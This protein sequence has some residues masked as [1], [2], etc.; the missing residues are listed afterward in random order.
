[1]SVP[2]IHSSKRSKPASLA[3]EGQQLVVAAVAA[4]QAQE[5]VRQDAALKKRIELVLDE[6]RQAGAGGLLGLG[7]ETLSVLLHRNTRLSVAA[8]CWGDHFQSSN[9]STTLQATPPTSSL[10][11]GLAALRRRACS[12]RAESLV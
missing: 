3:A 6:L 8:I 4:A 10:V 11:A 2:S 7:E 12:A 5:A 1:M 9:V